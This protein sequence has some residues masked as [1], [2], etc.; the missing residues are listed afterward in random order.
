LHIVPISRSGDTP[1]EAARPTAL[2]AVQGALEA[3]RRGESTEAERLCRLALTLKADYFDALYLGAIIAGQSGRAEEAAEL[4]ANAVRAN[5]NVPDVHYNR[6]V[7]LGELNRHAE[8]LDSYDRTIALKAD[9]VDAHYNRGVTLR[10]LG[11][12]DDALPSFERAIA[13]NPRYAEAH[14]NRGI[15]LAQLQRYEEALRAYEQAIALEANY[16]EAHN[17]RG[18]ALMQLGRATEALAA[19]DRAIALRTHY[20]Q[21]WNNRG[22][23][24]EDLERPGDAIASYERAIDLQPSY[25]EALY[26]RGNALRSAYRHRDAV[27]SYERALALEPGYAAA[28]WNLADCLLLLGDF[29]RGWQEYEWRWKLDRPG[30]EQRLAQPLW[31]GESSLEGRT[32]LLHSELGFGDTLLF[33]RY[34]KGVAAL[35]AE[36]VL[37]VQ[38]PLVPLLAQLDGVTQAV[39]QGSPPPPFDCHCPLMSLPLAFKTDLPTIP[40]EIPYLRS[41]PERVERWRQ[42][43]GEKANR[44]RIGLVW[45]GSRLLRNDR[46]SMPLAE[47]L[48]LTGDWAEWLSLQTDVRESDI[49]LLSSRSDLRDLGTALTDFAETAAAIELIDVLVTVDTSIAHVAGGMGKPVWIMLPRSAHD[50]RWMLDREDSPWY[51]TARLFRQ[52]ADGDWGSVVARVRAELIRVFGKAT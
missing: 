31:L 18:V 37:Q 7:A 50:W 17:N 23:A 39:A 44:P 10:E 12:P 2:Q 5:P 47:L 41:D 28:H 19:F 49:A 25:P 34:A 6:G 43:L 46:R 4:F 51:P 22:L 27:A 26:N 1:R 45:S 14:N 32:I 3:Y 24:L 20:A 30:A 9:H 36:V 35:G 11:R 52:A 40:A 15:A 48:R 42:R 13:L 38:P 16:A 33:C 8:A 21:A 29:A